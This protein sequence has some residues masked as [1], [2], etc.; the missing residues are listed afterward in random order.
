MPYSE[1]SI[2]NKAPVD[3]VAIA[4]CLG[5]RGTWLFSLAPRARAA[6]TG[7]DGAGAQTEAGAVDACVGDHRHQTALKSR[8][9]K[10]TRRPYGEFGL[11]PL[12]GPE[13]RVDPAF[14]GAG[15]A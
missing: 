7:A 3:A 4:V 6:P 5:V 10:G 2:R 14:V 13:E 11:V 8:G 15:A 9:G 1:G 12:D